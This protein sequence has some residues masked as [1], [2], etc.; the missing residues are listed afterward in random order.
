MEDHSLS[1]QEVTNPAVNHS[2]RIVIVN[3]V[4]SLGMRQLEPLPRDL[5]RSDFELVGVDELVGEEHDV[6]VHAVLVREVDDG[7]GMG[8]CETF[9]ERGVVS[10]FASV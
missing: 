4:E 2:V 8:F 5:L 3:V 10:T 6:F 9:K 7:G 1:I